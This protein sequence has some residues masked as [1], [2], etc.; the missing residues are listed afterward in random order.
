MAAIRGIVL[1][2]EIGPGPLPSPSAADRAAN[3]TTQSRALVPIAPSR[4]QGARP[5]RRLPCAAFL[6]HLIATTQRAPQTRARRRAEPA[7][8]CAAYA[9]A[10][11]AAIPAPTHRRSV[12]L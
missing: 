5:P 11:T 7:D 3:P 4:L 1:P 12:S 2:S 10:S 8:A 6:A 9:T